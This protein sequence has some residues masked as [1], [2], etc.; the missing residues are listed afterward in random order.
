[1]KRITRWATFWAGIAWLLIASR[2]RHSDRKWAGQVAATLRA[3][4]ER[5]FEEWARELRSGVQP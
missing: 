4:E 5:D 1:M 3:A 2:R